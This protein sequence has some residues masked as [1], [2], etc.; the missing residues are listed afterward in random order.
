M[1]ETSFPDSSYYVLDLGPLTDHEIIRTNSPSLCFL[2]SALVE[3]MAFVIGI[4]I[5][6]A[7]G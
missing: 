7:K 2:S 3:A 4:G 5:R 6:P 1:M